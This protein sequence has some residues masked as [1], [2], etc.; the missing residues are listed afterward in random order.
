[1]PKLLIT[2]SGGF[3]GWNLCQLAQSDWQVVGFYR[4]HAS[5]L[6]GMEEHRVDLKDFSQSESALCKIKPDAIIHTAAF[7][8]NNALQSDPAQGFGINVEVSEMLAANA[9]ELGIPFVFTSTDLV[10]DGKDG[11]YREDDAVNPITHYGEQKADAEERILEVNEAACICRMPLMLGPAGTPNR[12]FLQDFVDKTGNGLAYP[13]FQDEFRTPVG[14]RSAASGL[15]LAAQENWQG[16]FHMGGMERLNRVEIGKHIIGALDL[17]HAKIRPCLH[18]DVQLAAPRQKDA[19]LNSEKAY[20][21]GYKPQL[22][23]KELKELKTI[24]L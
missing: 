7:S 12:S 19:T 20:R 18:E 2:G 24:I 17:S 15:L 1:M 22:L 3:L 6:R 14:V 16:I 4:Q 11:M 5:N 21:K 10:F 8:N 13:L 23:F 9:A